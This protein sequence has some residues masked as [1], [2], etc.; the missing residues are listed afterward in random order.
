MNEL[1][2]LKITSKLMNPSQRTKTRQDKKLITHFLLIFC[3]FFR[4]CFMFVITFI[5][6]VWPHFLLHVSSLSVLPHSCKLTNTEA[7]HDS[8]ILTRWWKNTTPLLLLPLLPLFLLLLCQ[9]DKS[10]KTDMR[11]SVSVWNSP[12][13]TSLVQVL[14]HHSVTFFSVI[15]RC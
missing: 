5:R 7:Q 4:F 8:T 10:S 14:K 12:R 15:C 9:L 6:Q 11:C 1:N 13:E 2:E 3:L